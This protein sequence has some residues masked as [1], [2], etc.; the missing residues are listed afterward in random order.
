MIL[1]FFL[2]SWEANI[3]ESFKYVQVK[4]LKMISY[5]NVSSLSCITTSLYCVILLHFLKG[6]EHEE[7]NKRGDIENS[8]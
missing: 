6:S 1:C 5:S 8:H 4:S 7:R 3:E 2:L